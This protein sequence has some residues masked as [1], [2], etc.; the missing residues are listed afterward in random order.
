[1]VTSHS[2]VAGLIWRV[3]PYNALELDCIGDRGRPDTTHALS[4]EAGFDAVMQRCT[5]S[6]RRDAGKAEREGVTVGVATELS[7][8]RAYYD[9]YRGAL[10]RWQN[11]ATSRYGWR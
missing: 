3:N 2:R 11:R 10:E 8:W 5:G 1:M 7:E 6:R 4:L 9:I